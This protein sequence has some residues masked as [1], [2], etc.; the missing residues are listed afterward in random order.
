MS[1]FQSEDIAP[2]TL[3]FG[4]CGKISPLDRLSSPYS[5][6]RKMQNCEMVCY[7]YSLF[8]LVLR[9]FTEMFI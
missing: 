4:E 5:L 8:V 6:I 7:S 1:T 9:P 3:K 2:L